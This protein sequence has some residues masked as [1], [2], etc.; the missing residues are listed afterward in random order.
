MIDKNMNS[1]ANSENYEISQEVRLSME[2]LLKNHQEIKL[3][4]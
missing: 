4:H 1:K 3:A 2:K